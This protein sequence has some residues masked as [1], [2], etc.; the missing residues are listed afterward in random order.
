MAHHLFISSSV[1]AEGS[2]SDELGRYFQNRLIA[3]DPNATFTTRNVGIEPPPHPTHAYTIAN[4]TAPE[5][6]SQSMVQTLQTSD[7]LIDEMLAADTL[8]AAIP[9]YNFSVPSTFKA[10]VDNIVRV[11]RTF[12]PTEGG[13]FSGA[14]SGKKALFIT[15]RGAMYGA[16]S[17]IKE[18]DM[19]TPWLKT[20]FGFMGLTDIEF[21]H[22]D[23]LDFGG[24]EYR[25]TSLASAKT[26]LTE[27][28]QRW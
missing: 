5:D 17:P 21:V 20:V 25:D 19:Q 27:I 3:K 15:T 8:I 14:L 18:L 9:M 4:Y 1:R 12:F 10:Y 28:V 24:A 22:A 16:D 13:G 11:G 7:M 23:G 6:R 26:K 2:K